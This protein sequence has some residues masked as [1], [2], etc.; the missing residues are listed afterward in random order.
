MVVRRV[1]LFSMF[2]GCGSGP[3]IEVQLIDPCNQQAVSSVDWLRF[4]PRG[5]NVDSDGLA[6]VEQRSESGGQTSPIKIPLVSNFHLVATGHK[7][8]FDAPP[9]AIGVSASYDLTT[10]K[11]R[12]SIKLPFAMVD[13]FYKTTNLED[14]SQCTA[15]KVPRY[16]ASAT[17]LPEN[18]RV[19]IVGGAVYMSYKEGTGSYPRLVELYN[20]VSG[21][22]EAVAELRAGGA[23]AFHTATRLKDGRVLIAGGEGRVQSNQ[24]A[25]KSAFIIDARDPD[26]VTIAEGG[27]AMRQARTGHT[28]IL[29]GDGRVLLMGGRLLNPQAG[30]PR[31]S[32][33]PDQHRD[34]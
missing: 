29:L 21:E 23:R 19:L 24:E 33:L 16:G 20:P 28:A 13:N 10:A 17:Y 15:L 14:P 31:R 22:F 6:T 18:G 9:S 7:D 3:E 4:E 25:L 11:D 12:I 34:L 5:D 32:H 8:A 26:D 30:R 1:V 27:L 2:L